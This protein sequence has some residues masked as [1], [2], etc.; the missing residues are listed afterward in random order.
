VG[1][2]ILEKLKKMERSHQDLAGQLKKIKKDLLIA[3]L[4]MASAMAML[5]SLMRM[6]LM[7]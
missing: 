2:I 7:L 6:V 4:K 3:F 1:G 5:E